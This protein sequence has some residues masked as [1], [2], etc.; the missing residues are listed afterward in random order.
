[1]E[2]TVLASGSSGNAYHV[3][4]GTTP[5]LIEAG[6]PF[7]EIR[8]GLGFRVTDLAGCLVSHEHGDHA[9][10]VADM[11]R[12]GVDCYMSAGT[13]EALGVDGHRWA[14]IRAREQFQVGTWTVLP[15]EAVH[16]AAEPLGFLLANRA[17]EKLLYLTDSAYCRYRFA[18]LTHIVAEA[19]HSDDLLRQAVDDGRVPPVLRRRIRRNHMSIERLVDMLQANDLSRVREII[20]LHLS[21]ENS[22][23]EGFRRRVEEATGKPVGVA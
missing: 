22:D 5:L 12:S 15:F 11:M 9:R 3:T 6:I 18:G 16:D 1:M 7:P 10:A 19:N 13:V 23:A 17:G 20:L 8:R 4:D 21:D 14:V 2:I